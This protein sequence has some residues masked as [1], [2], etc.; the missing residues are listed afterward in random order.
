M[1]VR[2]RKRG[3]DEPCRLGITVTKKIGN[4]VLR[5]R[6]KRL[7]RESFRRHKALF[8]A[9]LDVV[10]IA[11]PK[12]AAVEFQAVEREMEALCRKVFSR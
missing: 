5:N 3:M 8:P 1:F 9:G 10:F 12:A 2:T 11:K 4:A 6:V 7:V